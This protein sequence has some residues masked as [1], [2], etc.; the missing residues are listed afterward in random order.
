VGLFSSRLLLKAV[1]SRCPAAGRVFDGGP[2]DRRRRFPAPR[3]QKSRA[4]WR[5][6][7]RLKGGL[8]PRSWPRHNSQTSFELVGVDFSRSERGGS[9]FRRLR[10]PCGQTRRPRLLE[11]LLTANSRRPAFARQE[12]RREGRRRR[13]AESLAPR[14]ASQTLSRSFPSAPVQITAS[15]C[16]RNKSRHRFC[17]AF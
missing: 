16:A 4:G 14:R 1:K 6:R 17:Q 12:A 2:L 8:S 15:R 9:N 11:D 7:S 10:V 3:F 5:R 13:R